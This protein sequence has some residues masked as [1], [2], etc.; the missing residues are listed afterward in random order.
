MT[1]GKLW[2]ERFSALAGYERAAL[3]LTVLFATFLVVDPVVLDAARSFDPSVYRFFRFLTDLGRSNWILIPSGIGILLLAWL[4]VRTGSFRR[5][6]AYGYSMQLLIFLFATV[7]L[8]GLASSLIKNVLGRA[9]PKLYEQ[10]GPLEFQPF[11]FDSDYASFPSGHATTAGALA[12]VLAI[13][14]PQ[15]RVPLFL[16]A[17]WIA[18]TRFLI[19]AHYVSDVVAGCLFGAGFAYF[20]RGRLAERRWLFSRNRDGSI[21]LRGRALRDAATAAISRKAGNWAR[22]ATN[23]LLPG[24]VPRQ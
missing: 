20:L 13:M 11:T 15:A 18:S 5:A 16:A 2:P 8:S 9:R 4:R 10:F 14:W 17:A 12:G 24:V 6:V 19:G 3:V 22:S 23:G 1:G 7:A 21:T